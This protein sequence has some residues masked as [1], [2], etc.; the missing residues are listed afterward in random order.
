VYFASGYHT[1][2]WDQPALTVIFF[3]N[4]GSSAL[5]GSVTASTLFLKLAAIHILIV[6]GLS[7]S[8]PP[9]KRDALAGRNRLNAEIM[10]WVP[11]PI[12]GARGLP[13]DHLWA[14]GIPADSAFRRIL[15]SGFDLSVVGA[16]ILRDN[17]IYSDNVEG[18][19]GELV[20]HN[21]RDVQ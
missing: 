9:E 19:A 4:P 16:A 1:Q 14:R 13:L 10:V 8:L 3:F 21:Q 6:V 18:G 17:R 2:E 5:F 12:V 7:P 20:W 11:P 15:T